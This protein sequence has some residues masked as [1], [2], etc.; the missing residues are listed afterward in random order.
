MH[1]YCLPKRTT[2][3]TAKQH[4]D[5][6]NFCMTGCGRF[7]SCN[8]TLLQ[9]GPKEPFMFTIPMS[10][11]PSSKYYPQSPNPTPTPA[12]KRAPRR[13]RQESSLTCNVDEMVMLVQSSETLSRFNSLESKNRCKKKKNPLFWIVLS[14]F[15]FSGSI[16]FSIKLFQMF[17][18]FF[19]FDYQLLHRSHYS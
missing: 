1:S 6:Y 15:H 10:T 5:Q 3:T 11:K 2:K 7:S 8:K 18:F 19:F 14:K 16:F 13:D 4:S 17:F 9:S 12:R